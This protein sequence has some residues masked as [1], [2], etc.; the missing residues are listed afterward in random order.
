MLY[1][2]NQTGQSLSIGLRAEAGKRETV[3]RLS[4]GSTK[5]VH[6]KMFQLKNM[7]ERAASK[8][9]QRTEFVL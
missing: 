1:G 9:S 6:C 3:D 2:A 8:L 5:H 4:M 7:S